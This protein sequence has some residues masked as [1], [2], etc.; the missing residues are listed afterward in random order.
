MDNL[1]VG[2]LIA[3]VARDDGG[4]ERLGRLSRVGL[5]VSLAAFT[6]LATLL[7]VDPTTLGAHPKLTLLAHPLMQTVGY[8]LLAALY[9][10]LIVYLLAAPESA[11]ARRFEAAWLVGLGK[12][13]FAIYL[14]HSPALWITSVHLFD[15]RQYDWP[16]PVEQG[17]RYLCA[18]SLSLAA[19][20]LSWH[21]L[22]APAQRLR[23]FFPYARAKQ[24]GSA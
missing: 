3:I 16:F 7:V 15:P 17:V 24:P 2:A 10:F 22:E 9:G 5:P 21:V 19:A 6:A 11:L 1:A 14:F 4:L 8:S 23:R 18:L 12:Y 20:W 13:S